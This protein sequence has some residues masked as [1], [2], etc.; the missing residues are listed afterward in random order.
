M[1]DKNSIQEYCLLIRNSCGSGTHFTFSN[2]ESLRE[3]LAVYFTKSEQ[4]IVQKLT[5]FR[6]EELVDG[7]ATHSWRNFAVSAYHFDD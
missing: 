1:E 7:M 6:P 4:H 2:V 3:S 5:T